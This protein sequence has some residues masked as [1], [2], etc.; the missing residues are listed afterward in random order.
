MVDRHGRLLQRNDVV[1]TDNQDEINRSV[2]R[3]QSRIEFNPA[4]DAY[5]LFDDNSA[6]GTSIERDGE[7]RTVAGSRGVALKDG[8]LIF[9]GKARARFF[10]LAAP[11]EG[12][13]TPRD[14]GL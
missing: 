6:Q 2:S 11:D 3:I 4:E 9:F 10:L 12:W 13:D 5:S 8:D 7:I 1:F 14:C